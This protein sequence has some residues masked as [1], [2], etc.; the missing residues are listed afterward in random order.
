MSPN[1]ARNLNEKT[2][3][4]LNISVATGATESA[5]LRGVRAA[6]MQL[7]QSRQRREQSGSGSNIDSSPAVGESVE[8]M[9]AP[10]AGEA[11]SDEFGGDDGLV[12]DG[13]YL[14]VLIE[15]ILFFNKHLVYCNWN[16][17]RYDVYYS[18]AAGIKGGSPSV[19]QVPQPQRPLLPF[20]PGR[21]PFLPL[22]P[23]FSQPGFLPPHGVYRPLH[24]PPFIR[25]SPPLHSKLP[26][27]QLCVYSYND[28]YFTLT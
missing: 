8:E 1:K 22:M 19:P 18:E 21:A 12:E 25:V 5:W 11:A 10:A 13:D 24:G 17:R 2:G 4:P 28:F 9:N 3:D 27:T 23:P 6:R 15:Q 26:L 20:P 7:K 16:S 14:Y